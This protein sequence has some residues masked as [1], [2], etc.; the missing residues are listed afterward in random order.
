LQL[1][2]AI[3]RIHRPGPGRGWPSVGVAGYPEGHPLVTAAE[4]DR[5]LV[6]KQPSSSYVVTQ[7]CFD[8]GAVLGWVGH[9]RELGVQLPVH[10]GIAGAVDRLKLV[11][12]AGRIGVGTSMRFLR[13]HQGG[14][15][16]LRPSGYRPDRLL[17]E[18]ASDGMPAVAGLHVYTLGD[19][20]TTER[21]RRETLDRLIDGNWHG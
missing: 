5:A 11:R 16:L 12:I 21:W 6:A 17:D 10:V 19:V 9:V 7:M 18:L 3:G 20:A 1:L 8:A 2:T 4:L 15:R 13:K 14:T